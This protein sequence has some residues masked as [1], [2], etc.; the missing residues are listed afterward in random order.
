MLNEPFIWFD[1]LHKTNNK[2]RKDRA[3]AI[4][5][6]IIAIEMMMEMYQDNDSEDE[7]AILVQHA[8]VLS[9]LLNSLDLP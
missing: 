9:D 6:G 2:Q 4:E 7:V 5:Q 8:V 3:A 1:D